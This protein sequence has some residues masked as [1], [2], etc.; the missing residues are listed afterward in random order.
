MAFVKSAVAAYGS[1]ALFVLLWSSGAIVSEL[2]LDH[3][4]AFAF[5]VLRFA[6]ASSVLAML[7]FC[8]LNYNYYLNLNYYKYLINKI[9]STF[10]KSKNLR[11]NSFNVD[12]YCFVFEVMLISIFVI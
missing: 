11:F 4:P 9:E 1:T 5:L 3:A 10:T 7:T 8:K 2:G 12:N 6:L